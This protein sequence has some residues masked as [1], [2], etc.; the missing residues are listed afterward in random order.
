[1]LRHLLRR[2]FSTKGQKLREVLSAGNLEPI[3]EIHDASGTSIFEKAGFKA[4]WISQAGTFGPE[5]PPNSDLLGHLVNGTE[6]PL[7]LN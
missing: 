5:D 7:V 1:M 3:A 4:L 2:K 6:A